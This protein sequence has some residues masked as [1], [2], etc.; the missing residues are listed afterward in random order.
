MNGDELKSFHHEALDFGLKLTQYQVD[1]FR[2]YIDELW[3][4]NQRINL[5]GLPTRKRIVN[6]LFLDSLIP[7][8]FLP[9]NGTMLDVGSGAGF[10]GI[11]LKIYN[12]Q[13]K[14]HLL[15]ANSK[16]ISFLKQIIRLLGL[17]EIKAIKGRIEKDGDK[18]HPDGYHLITARALAGLNQTMAW[19][20]PFLCPEGLLVMYLGNLT[21]E[22]LRK[23]K[24]V[25]KS[26]G[27]I[28]FKIAPYFLPGKKLKRNI[29][30]LKK[31]S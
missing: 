1:L 21:D 19:C 7:A 9:D 18:L 12:P 20:A 6:E 13:F 23:S 4:W 11:P 24:Q 22:D 15:E 8:P 14:T 2:C 29:F 25:M 31:E 27:V 3:Y 30:I 28:L 10:P 17:K 26:H 5:T 16:K